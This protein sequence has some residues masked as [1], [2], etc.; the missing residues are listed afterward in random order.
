MIGALP[1]GSTESFE[2]RAFFPKSGVTAEDPVTG[3][4]N[5]SLAQWLIAEGL[6]TPPYRTRQGT[7]LGRHGVVT[8][9]QTEPGGEI[10]VGGTTTTCVAG[11]LTA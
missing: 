8:I 7:A 5:A 3:S 6:A 4:L 10:W 2:V 11:T 1:A 9:D